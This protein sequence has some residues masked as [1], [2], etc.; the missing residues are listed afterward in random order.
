M[1]LYV[2]GRT[3]VA[4]KNGNKVVTLKTDESGRLQIEGEVAV[5]GDV[6]VTQNGPFVT[7]VIQGGSFIVSAVQTGPYVV[8]AIQGSPYVVTAVQGSPFV[9]TATQSGPWVVTAVQSGPWNVSVSGTAQI[10]GNVA[11]DADNTGN[12]VLTGYQ[13]SKLSNLPVAVASGDRSQ[14]Y[15]SLGG[16]KFITEVVPGVQTRQVTITAQTSATNISN[17]VTN[18]PVFIGAKYSNTD[19]SLG[20]VIS[21]L[22]TGGNAFHKE[23]LAPGDKG[24]FFPP[25]NAHIGSSGNEIRM[26]QTVS[27]SSIEVTT[28]W[29]DE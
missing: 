6:Q 4:G 12:P 7:T 21:I 15:G 3:V 11:H 8:T 26:S 20:T 19:A 25:K 16:S 13:A 29:L 14:D 5:T 2:D 17:T 24:E 9:V 18:V 1:S 22:F 23:F 28:Y 10:E 27:A